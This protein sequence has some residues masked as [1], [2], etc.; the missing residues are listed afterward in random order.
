MILKK[1]KSTS[2]ILTDPS[3]TLIT[4][5]ESSNLLNPKGTFWDSA[6]F[7]FAIFTAIF[8]FLAHHL[9]GKTNER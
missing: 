6:A 9:K 8:S 2:L 7:Y 1:E 4:V 3:L 5:Y